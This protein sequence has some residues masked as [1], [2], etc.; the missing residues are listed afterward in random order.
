MGY[1]EDKHDDEFVEGQLKKKYN[2]YKRTFNAKNH[3]IG[4][5]EREELNKNSITSEYMTSHKYT[6]KGPTFSRTFK[7]KSEA[8]SKADEWNIP[9]HMRYHPYNL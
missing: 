8:Q 3:P 5:K 4:S 9:N 6:V 1:I 7:T 2:V